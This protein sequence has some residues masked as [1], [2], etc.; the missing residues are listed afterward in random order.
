MELKRWKWF[1]VTAAKHQDLFREINWF[2]CHKKWQH[3]E[4]TL[5]ILLNNLASHLC[6]TWVYL[7]CCTSVLPFRIY[8]SRPLISLSYLRKRT[9]S[10]W[11]ICLKKLFF[12]LPINFRPK[13]ARPLRTVQHCFT[14][15]NISQGTSFFSRKGHR[16]SEWDFQ[17][18]SNLSQ[19]S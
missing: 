17:Q 1:P 18:F 2:R 15:P 5:L 7:T 4:K 16:F 10:N 6:L 12:F 19:W 3:K 14:Y 8:I 13:S 11:M 9:T